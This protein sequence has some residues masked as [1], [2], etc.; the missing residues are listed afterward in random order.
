[1]TY[2]VKRLQTCLEGGEQHS[3]LERDWCSTYCVNESFRYLFLV[4]ALGG[5][6]GNSHSSPST[7]GGWDLKATDL[8]RLAKLHWRSGDLLF[9]T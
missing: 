4:A 5:P 8:R 1:M 6:H 2:F 3:Y 7:C 9:A